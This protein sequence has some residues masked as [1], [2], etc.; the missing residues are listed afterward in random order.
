MSVFNAVFFHQHLL[1]H[2]P[3]RHPSKLRHLEEHTM[4]SSIRH[5]AQAVTLQPEKWSTP[6]QVRSQ[7]EQEG[8]RS[9]FLTTIVAYVLAL[10]DILHLWRL[11]VVDG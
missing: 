6:E 3:H 7:F 8:H 4:P 9:S 1:V 10:H 11:R 5:F 2:H